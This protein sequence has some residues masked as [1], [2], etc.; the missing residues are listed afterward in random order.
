[1]HVNISAIALAP[2]LPSSSL[3]TR[4]DVQIKRWKT[5]LIFILIGATPSEDSRFAGV[6]SRWRQIAALFKNQDDVWFGLLNEPYDWRKE[7]AA[8]S[9]QWLKDAELLVDNIRGT[10]AGHYWRICC[11]WR[12][13]LHQYYERVSFDKNIAVGVVVGTIQGAVSIDI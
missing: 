5:R 3:L 9:E 1:M 11:Q 13:A 12:A 7:N 4:M 10:G 2:C 8:S 6:Q